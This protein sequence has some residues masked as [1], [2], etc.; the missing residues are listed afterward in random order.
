MRQTPQSVAVCDYSPGMEY[1]AQV[2]KPRVSA[3]THLWPLLCCL[4]A[5]LVLSLTPIV[6]ARLNTGMWVLLQPEIE[7][8]LRIAGQAYYNH[9]SYISDPS[10]ADG[11]IFYPWLTF[12]PLTYLARTLGLS[13]FSVAPMWLLLGGV[14]LT[15]SLYFV[16]WRYLG[17]PWIAAGLTIL[18]VSDFRFTNSAALTYEFK[19]IWNALIIHPHGII[20]LT[21]L[22]IW[23]WRRVP[24]PALDLPFLFVQILAVSI[25]FDRPNRLNLWLSGLAFGL[26]FYVYFY[27]W[28]MAAA[29][30]CFAMLFDASR[31]KIYGLT[32]LIGFAC[33]SL[34]LVHLFLLRKAAS[35]EALTR[36]A[37]ISA[38]APQYLPTVPWF[39]LLSVVALGVW[40]YTTK[41]FELT[42]LWSLS[43][44]GI[45]LICSPSLTGMYLHAYH[46]TWL[47]LPIR[48]ILVLIFVVI[49]S[50][51]RTWLL[52]S[53]GWLFPALV[54]ICSISGV[55]FAAIRVSRTRTGFE[56]ADTY[57]KYREQRLVPGVAALATN[58][59]IAGD[60]RFCD[61]AGV[62]ENQ[63][64]L[65]DGFLLI[66][67]ALDNANWRSRFA[68]NEF[69]KGTTDRLEFAK[70][71]N[72]EAEGGLWTTVT[73]PPEL[74]PPFMLVWDEIVH[75]PDRF[76]DTYQVRYVALPI[77]Q[78]V[79][80]YLHKGWTLLQPGPYWRLWERKG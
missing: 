63:R 61:L 10:V 17:R 76:L 1:A 2:T 23:D 37:G 14:G 13:L 55:Y 4:L 6:I 29:A 67:M 42:Y 7:Y 5:G 56:Q 3:Q 79:P 49:L 70:K 12:V 43:A 16:F 75:D 39:S 47:M 52:R 11:V 19:A 26:L 44:A 18:C 68:L 53:F 38:V 40:I 28:T 9:L 36:F 73:V 51:E 35:N 66:S 22:P 58:S 64:V 74:I 80:A 32:L 31:R 46:W 71:A 15:T 77:D 69:L 27:V 45:L 50:T 33:G 41:R 59:M 34:E 78:P 8:Y 20:D 60:A 57:T 65:S 24:N 54:A 25:A 62:G 48:T 30:L 72:D 21:P